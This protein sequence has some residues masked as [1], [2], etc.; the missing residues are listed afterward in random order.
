MRGMS[1]IRKGMGSLIARGI[2]AI[3][4][5]LLVLVFFSLFLA[6]LNVLFPTGAGLKELMRAQEGRQ[7]G[8]GKIAAMLSN[9]QNTVK[10]KRADAI[11]WEN[12][13]PDAALF[14]QDA[15][16]TL[17][18]SSARLNFD[19]NSYLAM[20]A[21]SLVIIKSLEQDLS[22][23][24]KRSFLLMVEGE[25]RGKI[26]GTGGGPLHMEIATPA[27]LA[28]IQTRGLPGDKA[29]FKISINPDKSSTL[30]VYQGSAE[31]TAQGKEVR[32]EANE[33]V[34][35]KQDEAPSAPRPLP[36][37]VEPLSPKDSQSFLYRELSPRI[38]FTW[39]TLPEAT[40]YHF[41]L[42]R[43]H[44]FQD[45]LVDEHMPQNQFTH[46]N[47]KRGSYYWR[48]SAL[49][50]GT[51]GDFSAARSLHLAQKG[52][53][54]A[55]SVTFPSATIERKNCVLTGKAEPGARVFVMGKQVRT[56]EAGEF[57]HTVELEH[58][59]NIIVVEAVDAA[60]NVAYQSKN[61]NRKH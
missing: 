39:K 1:G 4:T 59:M 55:L 20:E 33:S 3:A 48:V 43:D 2:E 8:K 18:R 47:L 51:E 19:E 5:V 31:L 45:I 40:G 6:L 29:E 9:I 27:G 22:S 54:P 15:V 24:E 21:N 44:L 26:A 37:P 38:T 28:L 30:T 16:Q 58:G 10:S 53:P 34:M 46:G 25:L 57:S 52:T 14:D 42:A 41:V 12:A 32:V 36:L 13:Q 56:N 49:K 7:A 61:V 11:A 50:N 35:V 60:G 23:H 17:Q